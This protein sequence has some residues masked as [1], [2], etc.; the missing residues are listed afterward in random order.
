[1]HFCDIT[2][3]FVKRK[4]EHIPYVTVSDFTL[5]RE[6]LERLV[7]HFKETWVQDRDR[8]WVL[9]WEMEGK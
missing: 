8:V 9:K 2:D 7:S 6:L 5:G 3:D 4:V 1:M